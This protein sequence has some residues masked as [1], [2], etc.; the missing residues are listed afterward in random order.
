[1]YSNTVVLGTDAPID[2]RV[3]R[4]DALPKPAYYG[5]IMP[6]LFSL[7]GGSLRRFAIIALLAFS[8]VVC[9]RAT[10]VPS[11]PPGGGGGSITNA[12]AAPGVPVS[13]VGSLDGVNTGTGNKCIQV[14]IVSWTARGGMPVSLSLYYN[15]ESAYNGATGP[16]WTT[17]Y[18]IGISFDGS[19]DATMTWGD[20]G[21]YTLAWT[22]STY[23][24]PPGVFDTLNHVG[25]IFVLTTKYQTQYTYQI[26]GGS[27]LCTSISDENGNTI[28]IGRNSDGTINTVT[29]PTGRVITFGYYVG[30]GLKLIDAISDPIS[31]SWSISY[32][33]APSC[34]TDV[35]QPTLDS[36]AHAYIFG[37]ST[38]SF[39]SSEENLNL[40]TSTFQCNSDG[41]LAWEKDPLGHETS[42]TYGS[43][44]T[45]VTDPNGHTTV[46]TYDT[47]GRRVSTTDALSDTENYTWDSYNNL[48]ADK[49]RNGY[50][51][52]QTYDGNGNVLTVQSPQN[53]SS[54]YTATTYTYN[55][56]NMQTSASLPA[57]EGTITT[58]NSADDIIEVQQHGTH[59]TV[60][61]TTT[62]DYPYSVGAPTNYGL[63][64]YK[65]DAN[66]HKTSYGFDSNGYL[67]SATTPLGH[68]TQ[69][70]RSGELD[71][72]TQR[73]DAIGHI[74]TYT[75][76]GWLRKTA[77]SYTTSYYNCTYGYDYDSNLNSF[78]NYEGTYTRQYDADDR[79]TQE[80]LGGTTVLQHSYDAT[81]KL[82]LL[83][84][85]TDPDGRVLTYAYTSRN[86]LYTIAES[87][88]TAE[89]TYD[90]DG[91]IDNSYNENNTQNQT[92]WRDE[93]DR[94][95]KIESKSG[96]GTFFQSNSLTYD[97]DGQITNA[98]DGF[99]NSTTYAYDG[100]LHLSS[101]AR[102]G[103]DSY[104]NSYTVDGVGN[105]TSMVEGGTTTTLYHNSDDEQ[106]SDPY[107]SRTYA[108][109]ANGDQSEFNV[110]GQS[111][112]SYYYDPEDN[113][114]EI[115]YGSG[116][117]V[118]F[119]Y[120]AIGRQVARLVGGIRTAYYYDGSNIIAEYASS[121]WTQYTWGP[122]GQVRRGGEFTFYDGM[123]TA[124]GMTN[125]SAAETASMAWDAFG[126]CVGSTGSTGNPYQYK[127]ADGYRSDFD[128]VPAY[129]EIIKVGARYYDCLFGK[130]I[131][132][133][134]DLSQLPYCYCNG[135]P[136]N[137]VDP[138][139]HDLGLMEGYLAIPE[140]D[141]SFG[142]GRIGTEI[143]TD[144]SDGLED[145]WDEID[146]PRNEIIYG[147]SAGIV[148]ALALWGIGLITSPEITIPVGIVSGLQTL[149]VFGGATAGIGAIR[150][151]LAK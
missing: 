38:G 104:S 140:N 5:F 110:T 121:T 56:H 33:G 11:N 97:S 4:N 19:G 139:G 21:A 58:Y 36:Y 8:C 66:S 105:R 137:Y 15:S 95:T 32:T 7:M 98:L 111:P 37:Y 12:G 53:A 109:N 14:P 76:D 52:T 143:T 151:E 102:T 99:S 17:S 70:V 60:L 138:S 116:G 31:R 96:T 23:V 75:Y 44:S 16:K 84:T 78:A 133:D 122:G 68:E 134:K 148:S 48:T 146:S 124:F 3:A 85:M 83:S 39:I 45:T 77:T 132:R 92:F 79:L 117:T 34:L 115:S 127:N 90:A 57:G 94:L 91:C 24:D 147:T 88:G 126:N 135:D 145:I 40:N 2:M 22:G 69:W 87:T 67:S 106:T 6:A 144:L 10:P 101:E 136:I 27:W 29:D 120:D 73:T 89:Y 54:G 55:S 142:A 61:A 130:F 25:S 80:A 131:T 64:D 107:G 93:N 13:W 50:T 103:T 81:G 129:Q 112:T 47:S 9:A 43:T 108:Y 1:M 46:D 51:W 42:F 71:N 20:G 100:L 74:T 18:D 113:L 41:S 86:E 65:M 26:V 49:N 82:G 118:N 141:L 123:G 150:E 72:V 28:T 128:G 30:S 35:Y 149:G 62:V 119:G 59:G 125:S 63:P 114:T